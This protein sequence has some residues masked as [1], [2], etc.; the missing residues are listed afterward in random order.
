MRY[1]GPLF[2]AINPVYAREQL[3]GRG[4]ELYGGRFNRKGTPALY[5]SLSVVTAIK[6]LNQV[7]SLQPTALVSYEADLSNVF[8]C[9]DD[10]AL[11]AHGMDAAMLSAP[12]WRDRMK[13]DGEAPTQA[14]AARLAAEGFHALLVCSFA[15]GAN[16]DDLNIVL[17]QWSDQPPSRL[18][19][20]DDEGRL[21][22]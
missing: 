4:A 16:V 11:R 7:G 9:R 8:D 3:S 2:R 5:T 22:R 18:I 15:R 14:F 21:R 20:V 19:L 10:V 13:T 1:K 6:E 12:D 17:W